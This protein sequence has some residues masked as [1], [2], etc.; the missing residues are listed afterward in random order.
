LGIA[1]LF[2]GSSLFT[3]MRKFLAEKGDTPFWNAL[4]NSKD[5]ATYTVIAEDS[6][7]LA[8]LM[9]AG[10]GIFASQQLQLPVLDGVASIL[11]ALLLAA[12]ALLLIREAKGLLVGEGIRADTAAEIRHIA[13]GTKGVHSAAWPLSMYIGPEEILLVLDVKFDTGVSA[14]QVAA[15]TRTM[16]QAIRSRYARI[17]RIYIEAVTSHPMSAGPSRPSQPK[18]SPKAPKAPKRR[19]STI[20]PESQ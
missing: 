1:A 4:Q 18:K 10:V 7:A 8:G 13:A 5:P 11:I 16:E 12:V 20:S 17:K 6:A 14:E 19:S 2:E 15:S 3:A 9:I